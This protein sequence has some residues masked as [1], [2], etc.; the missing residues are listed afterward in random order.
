MEKK[1]L[2]VGKMAA[3]ALSAAVVI[4]LVGLWIFGVLIP[5]VRVTAGEAFAVGILVIYVLGSLAVA[6]GVVAALCQRVRELRSG[7]EEEARRY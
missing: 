2:P 1:P 7:E 6:V 5:L 4:A 3:A